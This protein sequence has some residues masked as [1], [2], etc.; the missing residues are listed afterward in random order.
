[1]CICAVNDLNLPDSGGLKNKTSC[2]LVRAE[3]SA[4]RTFQL[5]M[6]EN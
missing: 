6:M 5:R 3:I 2:F 1:M 4:A